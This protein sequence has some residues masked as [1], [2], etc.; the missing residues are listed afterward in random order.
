[1][2]MPTSFYPLFFLCL[3]LCGVANAQNEERIDS[4]LAQLEMMEEDTLKVNTLTEL[5][6][7][8]Y[9][10]DQEKV[11]HYAAQAM[12]LS[13][14]LGFTRGLTASLLNQGSGYAILGEYDK[15]EKFFQEVLSI[16]REA[17]DQYLVRNIQNNIAN[18]HHAQGDYREALDFYTRALE[19][20][21]ALGDKKG[22]AEVL[23]NVGHTYQ[24]KGSYQKSQDYYE[25]ALSIG[26]AIDDKDVMSNAMSSISS[27][28]I[29][30][31]NYSE[32]LD[33]CRKALVTDRELGHKERVSRDLD[34]IGIIQMETGDYE[35]AMKAFLEALEIA[36]QSRF[37]YMTTSVLDHIGVLYTRQ[38]EFKGALDF[39]SRS[40][41][42]RKEEDEKPGIADS[43]QNIADI[44]TAQEKYLE[45]IDFYERA[46][47][48]NKSLGRKGAEAANL[49]ALAGIYSILKMYEKSKKY[50]EQALALFRAMN[51]RH[52]ISRSLNQ[53]GLM[54]SMQNEH[55][56]AIDY[57]HEGLAIA[58]EIG[59]KGMVRNLYE[60]LA[61][62]HVK[63]RDYQKAFEY[64]RHY[65]A[66]KDSIFNEEKSKQIVDMQVKYETE[67][68]EKEN[69]LLKKDSELK[70]VALREQEAR[71]NILLL[72]MSLLLILI[73]AIV[74]IFRNRIRT[75]ELLA[76]KNEE[77]HRQKVQQL[78]KE[79]EAKAVESRLQGQES[80][81]ARIA[82]EL[83][84]GVVGSLT[85]IQLRLQSVGNNKVKDLEK[86]INHL[87]ETC[88]QARTLSHHLSPLPSMSSVFVE[89]LRHF[90]EDISE[91]SGLKIRLQAFPEKGLNQLA[92]KV[93]INTYRILQELVN[94][95]VKHAQAS[96]VVIDLVLHEE[97]LSLLVEDDGKGFDSG[98]QK[99][100][101]G[102][103]NIQSRVHLLGGLLHIDSQAGKG[104][105]VSARIPVS[106]DVLLHSS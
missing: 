24:E 28:L 46:M 47:K 12:V 71:Q 22:A 55:K 26:E 16:A 35:Q 6:S 8:Y 45:A 48:L 83:H 91:S 101:I 42:I 19:L 37:F 11:I 62:T 50:N 64:Q 84:D 32:A 41:E 23:I 105:T 1:M 58:K 25:K 33:Y 29:S 4:L 78:V 76:A 69:E 106:V 10:N 60:S 73:F 96:E 61:N 44:Y 54:Y 95:I 20:S 72:G 2:K 67:Q 43:Y 18:I 15:A 82:R 34:Y 92:E 57:F 75:R 31:G 56:K 59:A 49:V 102:L 94:N 79:Q 40:L 27:F 3:F 14:K 98:K 68:K 104:T 86:T 21:E 30:Q 100:G 74:L 13:K 77:L 87:E 51:D 103:Y 9:L 53:T 80:E 70:A 38:L 52:S 63:I 7:M 97:E 90:I 5:A 93:Q 99:K 39:F 17:G 65:T 89:S 88:Q 66:I 81:R 36:E 85:A